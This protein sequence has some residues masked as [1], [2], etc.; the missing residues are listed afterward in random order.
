MPVAVAAVALGLRRRAP[1]SVRPPGAEPGL[2]WGL[3]FD[4]LDGADD[5]EY[6]RAIELIYEGYLFHYRESRVCAAGERAVPRERTARRRLPLRARPAHR[7]R[8]R[9]RGRR[10]AA[11]ASHGRLL[12]PAQ[13]AG[14][15]SPPT[16]PCGRTPWAASPPCARASARPSG[17][18]ALRARSTRLWPRAARIDVP[19]LAR[20]EARRSACATPRHSRARSTPRRRTGGLTWTCAPSS[21]CSNARAS[22]RACAPRSTRISRW[23]RSP[24]AP[25]RRTGRRCSSSA[26]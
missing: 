21:A 15:R 2:R 10:R 18:A 1:P 17:R 14:A 20:D 7:R 23:P 13:R 8:A 12:V 24:T 9:R 11:G 3:L 19:A 4:E 25:A 16:T 6:V 5:A 22:W 26:R